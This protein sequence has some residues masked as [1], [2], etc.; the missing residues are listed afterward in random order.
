MCLLRRKP[1]SFKYPYR[2]IKTEIGRVPY[3]IVPVFLIK[4]KRKLQRDFIADTGADTTTLPKYLANELN[5]D[6]KNLSQITSQG[7]SKRPT[8]TWETKVKLQIGDEV[9]N[10][11]CSFVDSNKI[12]PLLGK[13][14][15]FDHFNF[16]FDNDNSCLVLNKRKKGQPKWTFRFL[17]RKRLG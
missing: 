3:P 14:D 4:G 15:I 12:P 2:F 10:A 5:I 17:R 8:K 16:L 11:H 1:P 13:L 7:I 9:I 6:L